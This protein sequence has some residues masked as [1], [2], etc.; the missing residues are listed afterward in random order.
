LNGYYLGV[1]WINNSS[2]L[3][4]EAGDATLID[5]GGF[6]VNIADFDATQNPDWAFKVFKKSLP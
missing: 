5:G 4:F 1:N 6:I 2:W 3:D